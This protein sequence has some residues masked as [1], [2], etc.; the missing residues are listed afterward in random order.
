MAFK[1]IIDSVPEFYHPFLPHVFQM[2]IPPEPFTSCMNCQMIAESRDEMSFGNGKPFAPDTKCCTFTPRLPNYMAGAILSDNDPEIQEGKKRIAGRIRS[3]KGILPNGVYPTAEY[4]KL[5]Q[6]KSST[7]F[8]RSIELL[9]PYFVN[10]RFNCSIWKFREATCALW[11]CK[12]IGGKKGTEF[13]QSVMDYLKFLQE[14]L[15]NIA[16]FK[17]GLH[18]VDIYGE[19]TY[20]GYSESS[21]YLDNARNITDI[22]KKWKGREAEY[23]IKCYEIVCNLD[24]REIQ[25]ISD[26]GCELAKRIENLAAGMVTVP[27]FL[28]V[29]RDLIRDDQTGHYVVEITSYFEILQKSIIWS[30]RLPKFILDPFN[31]ITKTS[32][33]VQL[34]LELHGV[35][36]EPEILIALYRQGI[37]KDSGI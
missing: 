10:G 22:W 36:V 27:E 24:V 21:E 1:K 14:S 23:Y 29:S 35:R 2:A 12:H 33:I 8:G 17:C 28:S 31:G 5:Y 16:A 20:P 7:G 30:F 18:P 9:C 15:M 19:G 11:F 13:W 32:G 3:D 6:A 26:H 25:N 34:I 4:N 37:L